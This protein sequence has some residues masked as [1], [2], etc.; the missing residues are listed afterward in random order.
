[1]ICRTQAPSSILWRLRRTDHPAT[2]IFFEV[3]DYAAE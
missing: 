2:S 3:D 1:M